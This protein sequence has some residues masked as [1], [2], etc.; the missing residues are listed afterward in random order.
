M[1][2]LIILYAMS[3]H[4]IWYYKLVLVHL[5]LS[6]ITLIGISVGHQKRNIILS[7][8]HVIMFD[9][10]L[11]ASAAAIRS[12]CGMSTILNTVLKNSRRSLFQ[13][14]HINFSSAHV[15]FSCLLLLCFLKAKQ[16]R[17]AVQPR[18]SPQRARL[19]I[20]PIRASL[21]LLTPLPLGRIWVR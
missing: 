1:R 14:G 12:H 10:Y 17:A 18:L 8:G 13:G 16:R 4:L 5:I 2:L 20:Q 3:I 15:F 21:R 9:N 7:H 19:G 6:L 11:T